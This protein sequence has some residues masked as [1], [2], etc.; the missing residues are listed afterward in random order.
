MITP[1]LATLVATGFSVAFFHA[2]LPTHWLPF[3]LVSRARGWTEAKTMGVALVA[4]LGH[5]TLTSLLGLVVAWLGFTLDEHFGEI[6]N[7]ITGGLL[8]AA[9]VYFAIQQL[10]GSG[11]QHHHLIGGQHQAS[12]SCGHEKDA[13]HFEH[14]LRASPL[15]EVRTGDWAAITGLFVMLTF[16][17]C[18]AFLPIYLSG[19]EFGWT[20]FWILSGILAVGTLGGMALFTWLTL[21]GLARFNFTKIER[22]EAGILAFGFG[23]LSFLM[24]F[25]EHGHDN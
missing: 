3:V 10:R 12:A 11:V 22:Y 21:R 7:H 8:L 15:S 13:S 23:A 16:S 1:V 6:F 24:F 25:T 14:E 18:E 5:V 9:S 20:G 4:G 19:V 2:A 17:P